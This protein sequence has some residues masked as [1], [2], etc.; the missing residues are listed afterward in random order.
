M[1]VTSTG[2]LTSTGASPD[3]FRRNFFGLVGAC[4]FD[5]LGDALSVA[6]SVLQIEKTYGHLL[7]DALE[8]GRA[9][10]DAFHNRAAGAAEGG[11]R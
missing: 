9:A 1:P 10:M 4:L 3:V 6:T 11:R 2:T 5:P 7:P 8:R